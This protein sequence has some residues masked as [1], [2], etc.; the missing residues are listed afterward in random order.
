MIYTYSKLGLQGG[1]GKQL[2]QI[3]NVV[4]R[5]WRDNVD[6]V[7]PDDWFF[8]PYFSIPDE[9]FVDPKSINGND[10]DVKDF[11]PE[12]MLDIGTFDS[13]YSVQLVDWLM[14]SEA[15]KPMLPEVDPE[16]QTV[17]LHVRK[18]HG[19][20]LPPKR[21]VPDM[22]YYEKAMEWH[23]I[24]PEGLYVFSDD[25]EWCEDQPLFQGARFQEPAPDS[26]GLP[27][28]KG[29]KEEALEA[30][31]L[32]FLTMTLYMNHIIGHSTFGW[33][34][35][36]VADHYNVNKIAA[37]VRWLGPQLHGAPTGNMFPHHWQR[38]F[39]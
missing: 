35:A 27:G 25:I 39:V 22:K 12:L 38:I 31:A 5:A 8:R 36:Y 10:P 23:E 7:F 4:S 30:A 15:I 29:A 32:D 11:F 18:R 16:D 28:V 1:L 6:F 26:V 33:W 14:P 19:K 21:Q 17:V 20:S 3:A 13:D 34:A 9:Y 2:F 37:P 24:G